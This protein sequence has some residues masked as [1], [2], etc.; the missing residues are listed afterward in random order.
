MDQSSDDEQM[1]IAAFGD[2]GSRKRCK[3]KDTRQKLKDER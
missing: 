3:K 2:R 1:N